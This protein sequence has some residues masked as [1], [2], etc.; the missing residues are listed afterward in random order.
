MQEYNRIEDTE[1]ISDAPSRLNKNMESIATDFS[2]ASFPTENL[3]VGMKC[4]RTDENKIYRLYENASNQLVWQ[5][6]YTIIN[7]G[8]KV[9]EAEEATKDA[10]GKA[11][12]SYVADVEVGSAQGKIKVTDGTGKSTE[13]TSYTIATQSQ[14]EA[15]TDN[16]S[17]M[18]ALRVKNGIDKQRPLKTYTS[19]LQLG[20]TETPSLTELLEAMPS[21]SKFIRDLTQSTG[22]SIGLPDGG[23]LEITKGQRVDLASIQL[24]KDGGD[25]VTRKMWYENWARGQTSFNW[26]EVITYADNGDTARTN[27]NLR[28]QTFTSL[29]QLG[30]DDTATPEQIAK[31]LPENSEISFY[32]I[33]A[34]KPTL[35]HPVNGSCRIEKRSTAS[36]ST[37]NFFLY[38][39]RTVDMHYAVYST[40]NNSGFSGWHKFAINGALSMPYTGA[41]GITIS[42]SALTGDGYTAPNDGWVAVACTSK[43]TANA[44]WARIYNSSRQALSVSQSMYNGETGRLLFP[45]AKGGVVKMSK[46]ENIT[47][48]QAYFYP[49]QS[50]V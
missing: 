44:S 27:L 2:G 7:G 43:A 50:E 45:V 21:Q 34:M 47:I 5:H 3:F 23:L 24:H 6:E 46:G 12:T 26:Q 33:N 8:I 9:K 4:L 11:I 37:V 22:Q 28:L 17:V 13:F 15:G 49:A 35:G 20:F 10:N 36:Y 38:A 30:L 32:A 16:D 48:D 31:A 40:Y 14:A 1:Y 19:F 25:D 41:G 42:V 29:E 39:Q 18:T